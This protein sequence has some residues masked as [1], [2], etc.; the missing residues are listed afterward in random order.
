MPRTGP[1]R[2][3]LTSDSAL[4]RRLPN[5]LLLRRYEREWLRRD[6]LAGVTVAAYLVPQVM[7]YA[8]VAGLP[9]VVGIWT[10]VTGLLV[11]AVLG[12]S[13]QLSMGP[14]STTS[15][16]TAV[17]LGGLA[18]GDPARFA[19]LAA[20][21]ALLVGIVCVVGW[22][23][24]LGFL[25]TL[26]SKP[27]LLGYMAG[28]A[29]I[30]MAS[31]LGTVT[32]MR[33]EGGGFLAEAVFVLTHPGRVHLPTLLL[34]T[35]VLAFL[36]VARRVAPHAPVPLVGMVLAAAVVALFGLE[37]RGVA[38]V[39]EIPA[40]LPQLGL[41]TLSWA[42]VV[43]L[44]PAA[45]GVAVVA[46]SDTVLTGRAFATRN[47]YRTDANQE[48]LA[49]GASNL[50]AGVTH[51]FPMSS[52][53]SRTLIGD[54]LGSRSQLAS[55]V[56]VVTVVVSLLVLR[57]VLGAFPMAALGAVV[58]YAA[59]GLIDLPELRRVGRF[60][61]TELALA[62]TTTVAVLAVGIL[63]GVLAA[64]GLSILDLFHRVSR[65]HDGILG[66]V[67]GVAGMH[68]IDDYPDAAS[69]PGLVVYRYDSPLFFANAEDFRA[70]SLAA[71]DAAED[72]SWFLLNAE[73]NVTI[74]LTAVDVLDE[75]RE[76]LATRGILMALARVKSELLADLRRAGFAARVGEDHI[77]A[78]LPTAVEAFRHR[79][80]AA[81][82]PPPPAGDEREE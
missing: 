8:R 13:R 44:L 2:E 78:T 68:D 80:D 48:L 10:T 15:L 82:G 61:R 57:P 31:Q 69:V 6:V 59:V 32:G 11:Y 54:A 72:V 38:V 33:V 39:G 73:A 67:P 17:A 27:V 34:A 1:P 76:E 21:L 55:L 81:S 79:A 23:V 77:F 12:S 16:M 71:V 60:R 35:G 52:S 58:V 5:L 63:G 36:L 22:V 20:L 43:L 40:G 41:P 53:G 65:P 75:L 66:Y 29:V 18:G 3:A 4:W 14:E 24:R 42:D 30:M 49:L 47:H 28:V 50:A 74:D 46:F 7:A 64:V 51:G 26:L 37:A 9:A 62:L 70:R 45:L 25:S 56:S 19:G